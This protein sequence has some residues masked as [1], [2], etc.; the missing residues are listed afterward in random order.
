VGSPSQGIQQREQSAASSSLPEL[1]AEL[2]EARRELAARAQDERRYR[3]LSELGSDYCCVAR[4]RQGRLAIEWLTG[5][6]S[7]ISGYDEGE[8]GRLGMWSIIAPV[9]QPVVDAAHVRVQLGE[10]IVHEFRIV[11]KS[12]EERWIRENLRP[13]RD[14][15][16]ELIVYV[17]A[18][19]V[20][21]RHSSQRDQESLE[22][23]LRQSQKMDAVGRLAGGVAHDFN[24]LLTVIITHCGFLL[25]DL[26]QATQ[27][28]D[29]AS[30]IQLAARRAAELT[31]RLLA[32]SRQQVLTPTVLDMNAVLRDLEPVL[33]TLLGEGIELETNIHPAPLRVKVDRAQ[34]EQIILN[35]V[36]N[37]RD[38]MPH[39]GKVHVVTGFVELTADYARSHAGATEGTHVALGVRDT[40]TGM[41]DEVL[42]R[43]FEPFFTTKEQGKGTGLGLSTVYGIVNQSGGSINVESQVGFGTTFEVFFRPA[44]EPERREPSIRPPAGPIT[45]I[46]ATILVVEDEEGVRRGVQRI[47]KHAGYQVLVAADP[48]QAIAIIEEYQGKIDMLLT[49][50]V[51]PMMTGA[52]LAERVRPM[53]LGIKVLFMSGHAREAL[54]T[55]QVDGQAVEFLQKPFTR[56]SML[57]KV[58]DVLSSDD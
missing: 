2:A 35:L 54:D 4:V 26:P 28:H 32:F 19:D 25:S 17:A 53:R 14:H 18:R 46:E 30:Q 9:D 34:L 38:A 10:T 24:N 7:R 5:A 52:Q 39:G 36:V 47:L 8:L 55:Q 49:D 42:A 51:M 29:D 37:A 43:I 22:A 27:A 3:V 33:F 50:V 40:G 21:E 31:Q 16:G 12:G 1:L 58:H 13:E 20:T 48:A 41:T 15:E 11:T 23:Q 56:Q 44:T 45:A 6:T 57:A